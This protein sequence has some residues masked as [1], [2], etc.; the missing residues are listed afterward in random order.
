MKVVPLTPDY[1]LTAFD[2]G[3]EQLNNFLFEDAK[4]SLELRIANTFILEDDGRIVAYFCLLN[5]KVSKDEIIGSR[6]KK[7]RAKFPGG[8]QFRS[9]PTV[10]IGRFA[11]AL[12]YRGRNIGSWLMDMLKD[13]LEHSSAH[14]AF[15][16][17][18]VDAYLSAVPFY[19]KNG[20]VHLTKKDE[21][22]HTRLMFF[23]MKE[24]E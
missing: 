5:D 12:D 4:P 3:D 10:K 9:Y 19:E 1:E 23:D 17:I 6:W 21:D 24:V 14:S 18:T 11:V 20:F 8:K 22:E 15:R 16:Y 7:I 13:M 2:C